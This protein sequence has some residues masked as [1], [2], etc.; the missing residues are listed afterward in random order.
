MKG[1]AE[2]RVRR[3]ERSAADSLSPGN[4]EGG[5]E[6]TYPMHGFRST[7]IILWILSMATLSWKLL[8]PGREGEG[9]AVRKLPQRGRQRT[10]LV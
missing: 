3:V 8:R 1:H 7:P 2:L 6:D 10:R 9:F 4:E 5:V